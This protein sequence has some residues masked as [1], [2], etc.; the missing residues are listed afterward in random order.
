MDAGE[1]LIFL[2]IKKY[3]F[4]NKDISIVRK[5]ILQ[6]SILFLLCEAIS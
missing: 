4:Y 5:T 3:Y 6:K 1:K 2:I